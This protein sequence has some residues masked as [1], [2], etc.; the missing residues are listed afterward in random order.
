MRQR[1]V[2]MIMMHKMVN[3]IY[4]KKKTVYRLGT[5]QMNI[6]KEVG[7]NIEIII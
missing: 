7:R 6:S 3:M 4:M 1:R 2:V 5:M